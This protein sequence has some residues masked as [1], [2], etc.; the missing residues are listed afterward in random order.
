MMRSSYVYSKGQ[1]MH[2]KF[3]TTPGEVYRRESFFSN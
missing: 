1:A 2:I 3:N